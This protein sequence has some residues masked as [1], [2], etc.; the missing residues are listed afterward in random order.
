MITKLDDYL[1]AHAFISEPN[2]TYFMFDQLIPVS[3]EMQ[4]PLHS[5]F[6]DDPNDKPLALPDNVE[7][8]CVSGY[9]TFAVINNNL[10]QDEYIDV[11]DALAT[12]ENFLSYFFSL[13]KFPVYTSE[14][15][16]ESLPKDVFM[17]DVDSN[18][19]K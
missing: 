8:M 4:L 2:R 3:Y 18:Y 19:F 12:D 7:S 9:N 16:D 1:E 6:P 13:V 10:K 11:G 17:D 15:I 14:Q 5:F